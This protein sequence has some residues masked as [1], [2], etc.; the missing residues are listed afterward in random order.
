MKTSEFVKKVKELG[1]EAEEQEYPNLKEH[2]L[3][4]GDDR[5]WVLNV[6]QNIRFKIGIDYNRFEYLDDD[7]KEELFNIAV[8]YARTPVEERETKC[9][10]ALTRELFNEGVKII[11]TKTMDK[12]DPKP[13]TNPPGEFEKRRTS[14]QS[15]VKE[16]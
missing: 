8:E 4:V 11:P 2:W 15:V 10:V 9:V 13:N 14:Y 3:V 7:I 5:F 6:E 1:F 12:P 16:N